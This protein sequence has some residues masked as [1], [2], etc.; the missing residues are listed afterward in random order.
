MD[1]PE[2]ERDRRAGPERAGAAGRVREHGAEAEHVARRSDR[3]AFSLLGG[4]KS[5]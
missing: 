4:E 2:G 5:G 3:A 1:D